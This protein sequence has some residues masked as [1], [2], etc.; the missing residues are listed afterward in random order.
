MYGLKLIQDKLHRLRRLQNPLYCISTHFFLFRV[1]SQSR[2]HWATP[3]GGVWWEEIRKSFNGFVQ[4]SIQKNGR[5]LVYLLIY[6]TC[7][8]LLQ[9]ARTIHRKKVIA[10]LTWPQMAL[11]RWKR[12]RTL[13]KSPLANCASSLDLWGIEPVRERPGRK[14]HCIWWPVFTSLPVRPLASRF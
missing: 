6:I 7:A 10:S 1:L 13:H 8:S 11:T 2:M 5:H 3:T 14:Q 12:P 9:H 4:F